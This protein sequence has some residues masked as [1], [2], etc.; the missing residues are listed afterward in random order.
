MDLADKV[1]ELLVWS[2]A[3]IGRGQAHLVSLVDGRAAYGGTPSDQ[4]VVAAIQDLKA[5][6]CN[7]TL[8]PFLLMDIPA[9]NALTDPY[10][11]SS[12][13]PAYPWRGRITV[14]PAP[15][16]PGTPDKTAAAAT[17]VAAFVG[18]AGVSDFAIDEATV[19]YS[20]PAEWSYRR[21]ILH[22]AHLAEAAGG[23]RYLHR[24]YRAAR[25]D[26]GTR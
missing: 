5:R 19:V 22:Y 2:V 16:Q 9:G 3:G 4:T 11:G 8:T 18:T 6:G 24:R 13:Q 10:T 26:D 12:G 21:F 25:A 23:V 7:V 20:G 1:T 15:G 17:Q 14:S